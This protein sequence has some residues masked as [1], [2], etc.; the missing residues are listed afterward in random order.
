MESWELLSLLNT[1]YCKWKSDAIQTQMLNL[2][3]DF[4]GFWTSS[5]VVTVTGLLLICTHFK[6]IWVFS[7]IAI[8]QHDFTVCVI[9]YVSYKSAASS[10]AGNQI[11]NRFS[12]EIRLHAFF[13]F[14][15]FNLLQNMNKRHW[16][17]NIHHIHMSLSVI[18]D[19]LTNNYSTCMIYQ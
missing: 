5:N 11:I 17:L 2:L 16:E 9:L 14:C 8:F 3:K 1:Q 18:C 10:R 13:F 19:Q 6:I 7:L 12:L 15:R 4:S